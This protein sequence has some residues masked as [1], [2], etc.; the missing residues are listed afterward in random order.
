MTAFHTC[1]YANLA[2]VT[3]FAYMPVW[4]KRGVKDWTDY[5]YMNLTL[6]Y[7]TFLVF[8]CTWL[9]LL[10]LESICLS[11]S[12]LQLNVY[13][14]KCVISHGFHVL[15]AAREDYSRRRLHRHICTRYLNTLRC[16]VS[17]NQSVHAHK[18]T[19]VITLFI[20]VDWLKSLHVK[21]T[22]HQEI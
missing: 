5:A 1:L 20:P 14:L 9:S 8:S 16:G 2:L 12:C 22:Q 15:Q 13:C 21:K 19:H 11:K 4:M 3:C 7:C 17:F 10:P 18:I 6:S